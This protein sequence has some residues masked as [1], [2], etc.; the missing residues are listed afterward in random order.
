MNPRPACLALVLLLA[1]CGSGTPAGAPAEDSGANTANI[2]EARAPEP[3]PDTVRVRLET[4]DGAIVLALDAKHAPITAAN[5]V[6]YVDAHRFDGTS[7]YRAAR[8]TGAPKHGFIQGGIRREYRRMFPPIA[9]EPTSKT[10]LKHVAGT[11]SMARSDTPGV[12][13]MGD[14]FILVSAMPSLNAT[15][16]DPGYAAFGQVVEGMDVVRTILAAETVPNA[17]RGAMRGEMIAK[18]VKIISA[19]RVPEPN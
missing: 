3:L 18:P 11:I 7:F 8:T 6:R 10:G 9:H 1:A 12:G 14:F 4:D 13:A 5:F 16:D 19:S 17:G 2:A 15:A